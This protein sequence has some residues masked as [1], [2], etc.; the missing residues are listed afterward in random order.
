MSDSETQGIAN[1]RDT[2]E[3][4]LM[5]AL[6]LAG[7]VIEHVD[8]HEVTYAQ[9]DDTLDAGGYAWALA[10]Q[11]R[12]GSPFV[13]VQGTPRGLGSAGGS[14]SASPVMALLEELV[15]EMQG[16]AAS[17]QVTVPRTWVG[18][19]IRQSDRIEADAPYEV[20]ARGFKHFESIPTTYG[21]HVEVRES[22][23]AEEAHI[24][25]AVELTE[26]NAR[27]AHSNI[28]PEAAT[29]HM[30]LRDAA[31]LRDQLDAAIRTHYH[32]DGA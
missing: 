5:A 8:A 29:A 30:T 12:E 27:A 11:Y 25:L 22:S 15:V 26:D 2:L 18:L 16:D 13:G 1:A 9:M 21:H 3:L 6:Q 20:S 31:T 19:A 17:F 4:V 32:H 10:A 14:E 24:W 28:E 7:K 23:H